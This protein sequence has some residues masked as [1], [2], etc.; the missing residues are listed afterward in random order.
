MKVGDFVLYHPGPL[1]GECID[2]E[3]TGLPAMVMRITAGGYISLNVFTHGKG[4]IYRVAVTSYQNCIDL[5]LS[6][7]WV[8]IK[9]TFDGSF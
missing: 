1:D 2:H 8:P 3:Q 4:I 6:D 5:G 9:P 7:Y